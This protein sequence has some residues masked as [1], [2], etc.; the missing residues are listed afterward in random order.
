MTTKYSLI[1]DILMEQ[2]KDYNLVALY[3]SS[4]EDF[5][6][7]LQG[8]L[9]L[10]IADFIDVY[11]QNLEDRDDD[12]DEE[13]NFDMTTENKVI[14]AQLMAKHWL[15]KEIQDVLQMNNFIF[16]KDF[17]QHSNAQGLRS[18]QDLLI[19]TEEQLDNRLS[20]YAYRKNDWSEWYLENFSGL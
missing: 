8:F 3:Q 2:I 15:K 12:T 17:K 18:K 9:I 16:D 11:N 7:Y 1:Y 6:A 20:R 14:L 4:E 5:S 19:A 10:A 13:F